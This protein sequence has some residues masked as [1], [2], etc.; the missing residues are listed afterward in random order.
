M[1]RAANSTNLAK[2]ANLMI[3]RQ[4]LK[5]NCISSRELYQQSGEFNELDEFGKDG[6]YD[7]TSPKTEIQLN[8]L[9]RRVPTERRIRRI[10]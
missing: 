4:R 1:N 9:K 10:P 5:L 6:E 3:F 7:D 2:M 8:K